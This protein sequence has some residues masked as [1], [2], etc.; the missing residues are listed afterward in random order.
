[1]LQHDTM[2]TISTLLQLYFK[3]LDIQ[4]STLNLYLII[5]KQRKNTLLYSKK[6]YIDK[7]LCKEVIF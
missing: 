3:N 2:D 4:L 5:I 1:M 6:I 7:S